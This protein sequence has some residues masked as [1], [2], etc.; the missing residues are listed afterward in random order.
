MA[1][2]KSLIINFLSL[3]LIPLVLASSNN[4]A[5][6]IDTPKVVTHV[7]NLTYFYDL[8]NSQESYTVIKY[9]T[10]WCSHCKHLS[11]IF[12]KV[13]QQFGNEGKKNINFIEVDCDEFG[14]LCRKLDGFPMIQLIKRR[15]TPNPNVLAD[16]DKERLYKRLWI[17]FKYAFKNPDWKIDHEYSVFFQGKR[18]AENIYNFI[19]VLIQNH[20]NYSMVKKVIDN[21][22]VCEDDSACKIG[23]TF[24]QDII[25]PIVHSETSSKESIAKHLIDE[26]EK[27]DLNAELQNEIKK[28]QEG[29]VDYFID[30]LGEDYFMEE[31]SKN[32]VLEKEAPQNDEL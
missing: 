8:V 10:T 15:L 25:A 1:C 4:N 19:D 23:K 27:I 21:K 32:E 18:N 16:I 5:S 9:Y 29:I 31:A 6:I 7:S 14:S 20:E 17:K 30:A 26:R 13:G 12:E 11:P 28:L 3:T 24:Y 22:F 2:I